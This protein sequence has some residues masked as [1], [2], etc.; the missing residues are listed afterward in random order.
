VRVKPVNGEVVAA[1]RNEGLLTVPAGESVVRFL[2]PL[3]ISDPEI[4]EA[5]GAFDRALASVAA[6]S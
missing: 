2:P 6:P 1:C 4:G 3:I 5:V